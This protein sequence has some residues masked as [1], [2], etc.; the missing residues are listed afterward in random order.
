MY[1]YMFSRRVTGQGVSSITVYFYN[2]FTVIFL[3]IKIQNPRD[4]IAIISL[5]NIILTI[6]NILFEFLAISCVYGIYYIITTEEILY[7]YHHYQRSYHIVIV[8]TGVYACYGLDAKY[9]K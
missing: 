5:C 3:L 9:L 6:F 4:S 7:Q 8:I 1:L 2:C